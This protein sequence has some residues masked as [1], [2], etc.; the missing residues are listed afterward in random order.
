MKT[1]TSALIARQHG[2]QGLGT[3]VW[4]FDAR[5]D[6]STVDR[7]ALDTANVTF[8]SQTYSRTNLS[9]KPPDSD[10]SGQTSTWILSIGD[11]EKTIVSRLLAGKYRGQ[12]I[13]AYLVNRSELGSA[14]NKIPLNGRILSAD[15]EE[16]AVSF[17]CGQCNLRNTTIPKGSVYR[18]TCR[19]EFK[20]P[21][22]ECGYVGA[23]TS[24][25]KRI[26][27]CEDTM[28]NKARFGGAP[29]LPVEH[30]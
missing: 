25:D 14:S 18:T 11:A 13:R 9:L 22:G 17:R 24:C 5:R 1:L 28:N 10:M 3:W 29:G 26:E 6:S 2:L 4:I 8:N 16:G 23:E 27:T 7:W 21:C 12:R 15:A 19:W 20:G 30:P